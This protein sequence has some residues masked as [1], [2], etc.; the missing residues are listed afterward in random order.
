M[1]AELPP[2]LQFHMAVFLKH[3]H[4]C[5]NKLISQHFRVLLY[6]MTLSVGSQ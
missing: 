2:R 1:S 6:D 3:I 4:H 5:T